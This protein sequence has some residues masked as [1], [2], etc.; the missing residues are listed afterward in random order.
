MPYST[1]TANLS[2]SSRAYALPSGPLRDPVVFRG[3]LKRYLILGPASC[4]DAFSTYQ[5][6][7]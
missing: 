4:L 1:Y 7:T 6:G 5:L 2:P 3:S